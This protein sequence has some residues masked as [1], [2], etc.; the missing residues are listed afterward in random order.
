MWVIYSQCRGLPLH[1]FNTVKEKHR[2]L[3]FSMKQ[4]HLWNPQHNVK[5]LTENIVQ[6]S[7]LQLT[8]KLGHNYTFNINPSEDS[9][10]TSRV[11]FPPSAGTGYDVNR[12]FFFPFFRRVSS[13][14]GCITA[15][16]SSGGRALGCKQN[17]N[18]KRWNTV[19]IYLTILYICEGVQII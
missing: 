7:R 6:D 11:D 12:D 10:V 4:H 5:L 1:R 3:C 8:I 14:F 17:I 15:S 18:L 13:S 9:R 2:L 16:L 19:W